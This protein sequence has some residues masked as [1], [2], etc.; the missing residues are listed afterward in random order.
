MFFFGFLWPTIVLNVIGGILYELQIRQQ[1][2]ISQLKSENCLGFLILIRNSLNLYD[3]T[4]P[5]FSTVRCR[6]LAQPQYTF[7]EPR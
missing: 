2:I 3:H 7:Q 6:F 5:I 1:K 4:R